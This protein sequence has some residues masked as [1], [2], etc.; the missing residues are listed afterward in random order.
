MK[1]HILSGVALATAATLGAAFPAAA[2]DYTGVGSVTVGPESGYWN[3][4]NFAYASLQDAG[5]DTWENNSDGDSTWDDTSAYLIGSDLNE[6][7]ME[8]ASPADL[9][10]ATDGSGDWIF[11]C[12]PQT[13]TTIDGELA[14]TTELRFFADGKTVRSRY[15]IANESNSAVAGNVLRIEYNAYQDDSTSV[16]WTADGGMVGDWATDYSSTTDVMTVA[17]DYIWVTD[18]REALD[19]HSPVV[20]Y[21]VGVEDSL[22]PLLDTADFGSGDMGD[23]DDDANLYYALPTMEPGDVIEYVSM[24]KVFLFNDGIDNDINMN[25][26]EEGTE[27]AVNQAA[28]DTDLESD[29]YVFTG[30]D[31]PSRVLNWVTE[32]GARNEDNSGLA[33]T[34]FDSAPLGTIAL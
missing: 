23:G 12:D 15:I 9:S 18:D 19:T 26:W 31:N 4:D 16:S 33:A 14:V 27:Y 25:G 17:T 5:N 13:V 30:I 21:A 29:E 32:G 3:F 28:L 7:Q 1:K 24:A 22:S 34:G 10:E 20:K 2:A 11:T 8:C 6:T